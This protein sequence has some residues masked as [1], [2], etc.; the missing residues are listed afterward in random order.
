MKGSNT[1]PTGT[2]WELSGR[3][4]RIFRGDNVETEVDKSEP[5]TSALTLAAEG[6]NSSIMMLVDVTVL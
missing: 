5:N 6:G 3:D 1:L 2:E 4:K